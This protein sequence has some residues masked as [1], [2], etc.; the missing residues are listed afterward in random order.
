[1]SVISF[2]GQAEKGGIPDEAH[3]RIE[4]CSG[5]IT[6]AVKK[7]ESKVRKTIGDEVAIKIA[8]AQQKIINTLK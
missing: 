3:V 7:V 8:K 1:M 6:P 4:A 2:E 5:K